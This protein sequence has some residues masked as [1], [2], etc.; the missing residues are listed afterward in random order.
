MITETR[1]LERHMETVAQ[2]K[3]AAERRNK[4]GKV[5]HDLQEAGRED[6]LAERMEDAIFD[7][8]PQTD[9]QE[10]MHAFGGG[11]S[12]GP[13]RGGWPVFHPVT[14]RRLAVPHGFTSSSPQ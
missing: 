5:L 3:A 11:I 6:S 12:K 10:F 14:G 2:S 13:P 7:D 8:M 1:Q 4:V 9:A